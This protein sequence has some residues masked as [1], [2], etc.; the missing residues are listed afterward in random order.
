MGFI[1]GSSKIFEEEK[2]GQWQ[3][4]WKTRIFW[5]S[6]ERPII[7]IMSK[8]NKE[9]EIRKNEL[10]IVKKI[11]V[12]G[13]LCKFLLKEECSDFPQDYTCEVLEISVGLQT[14]AVIH[15]LWI[16]SSDIPELFH[17]IPPPN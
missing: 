4:S 6:F 7:R 3:R 14:D 15:G 11:S 16:I 12:I 2:I 5:K 17:L 8:E 1:Q 13:T 10:Q 9:G